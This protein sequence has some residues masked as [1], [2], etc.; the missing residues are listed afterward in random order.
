VTAMV[1]PRAENPAM[2]GWHFGSSSHTP[3]EGVGRAAYKV[4]H[5]LLDCFPREIGTVMAGIFPRVI[6]S[7]LSG[8][9]QR[10]EL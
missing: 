7:T 10:V 8:T 2:G 3:R 1:K 5:D 9:N 4:L 6:L